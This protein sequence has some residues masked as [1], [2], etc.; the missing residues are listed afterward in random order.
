M[1]TTE[2]FT[3]DSS[4]INVYKN[5]DED[6]YY[7]IRLNENKTYEIKFGNDYNGQRL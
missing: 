6:R 1:N 4:S 5:T 7:T 3:V 2:K